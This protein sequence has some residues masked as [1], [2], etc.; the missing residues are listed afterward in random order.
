MRKRIEKRGYRP[1]LFVNIFNK[2]RSKTD[3]TN[4]QK[5]AHLKSWNL[6]P[7]GFQNGT[8]IDATSHR[9]S[10]PKP[11]TKKIRKSIKN[12]VSLNGINIEFNYKTIVFDGWQGCMCER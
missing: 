9:K 4:Q 11:V 3:S 10:M 1:R 6:M 12:I 2:Q 8:Q 5:N 7:K